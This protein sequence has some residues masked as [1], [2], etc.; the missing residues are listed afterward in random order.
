MADVGLGDIIKSAIVRVIRVFIGGALA[1]GLLTVVAD[2][3]VALSI[4][5]QILALTGIISGL[6]KLLRDLL[7]NWGINLPFPLP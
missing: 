3:Q 5:L 7:K 6:F 1:G 2:L 4:V